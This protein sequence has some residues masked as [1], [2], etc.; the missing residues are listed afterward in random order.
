MK[1]KPP[2]EGVSLDGQPPINPDDDH[3]EPTPGRPLRQRNLEGLTPRDRYPDERLAAYFCT[4]GEEEDEQRP[5]AE[6][7][8]NLLPREGSQHAVS[9]VPGRC[10]VTSVHRGNNGS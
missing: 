8:K 7:K 9:L 1:E 2:E 4:R 10:R 6:R 3:R 5:E